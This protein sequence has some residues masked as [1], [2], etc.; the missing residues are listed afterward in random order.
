MKDPLALDVINHIF[1]EYAAKYLADLSLMTLPFGGVF[2]TGS[3]FTKGMRFALEDLALR[4]KFLEKYQ[5]RGS[6]QPLLSK[7][8]VTLVL[9]TDLAIAGCV[10]Y[11]K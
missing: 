1:I 8:P 2:L 3:V 5:N 9:K 4:E 10:N 11:C 7:I 6:F